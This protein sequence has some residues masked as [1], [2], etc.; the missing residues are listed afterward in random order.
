MQLSLAQTAQWLLPAGTMP[1]LPERDPDVGSYLVTK[2]GASSAVQVVR[3]PGRAGDLT[4]TWTFTSDLDAHPAAFSV[5][6]A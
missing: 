5:N 4:P 2:P 3:A 6:G 1:R